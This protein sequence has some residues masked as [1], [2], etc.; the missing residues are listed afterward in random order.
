MGAA[1]IAWLFKVLAALT[2]D[3]GTIPSTSVL[4]VNCLQHL[5]QQIR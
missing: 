1:E 3:P 2:E 5:F 4:P